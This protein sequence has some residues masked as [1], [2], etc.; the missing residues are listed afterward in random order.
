MKIGS[1]IYKQKALR[2]HLHQI[3]PR[4][5]APSDVSMLFM[6]SCRSIEDAEYTT[7]QSAA[8]AAIKY[9]RSEKNELG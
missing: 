9:M 3:K 8:E 4:T 7:V 2:S 5:L 1:I 6:S